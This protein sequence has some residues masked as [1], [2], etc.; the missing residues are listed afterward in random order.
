MDKRP[1]AE[2]EM[3]EPIP[4]A[5]AWDMESEE[6]ALKDSVG[7]HAAEFV[8][9]YPPGVP[10]LVPGE[11]M[12]EGLYQEIL[13]DLEAELTV[14]GIRVEAG[15]EPFPERAFIRLIR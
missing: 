11:R 3:R 7:K 6:V 2:E 10:L 14:Q 12:T 1:A 8:N 5:E 15:N 9:L 13:R 4:L